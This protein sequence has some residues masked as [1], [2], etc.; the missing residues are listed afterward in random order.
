MLWNII[1]DNQD[2]IAENRT[3]KRSNRIE[4]YQNPTLWVVLR[5][6]HR[7]TFRDMG[8]AASSSTALIRLKAATGK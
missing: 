5:G 7:R 6:L 1:E 8:S 2:R 4:F 3:E